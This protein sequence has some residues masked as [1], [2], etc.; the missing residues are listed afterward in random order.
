MRVHYAART[1]IGLVRGENQD[2][3][4]V[5]GLVSAR[6]AT[7]SGEAAVS[8]LDPP[9]VFGVFDGLGGHAGGGIASRIAAMVVGSAMGVRTER[10]LTTSLGRANAVVNEEGT[11]RPELAG[12][13]TTAVVVSV[14]GDGFVVGSVGDSMVLRVSGTALEELTSPDRTPDPGRRGGALLTQALG[15]A[16]TVEVHTRTHRLSPPTRLMLAT[17]GLTDVVPRAEIGR[18]LRGTGA[19]DGIVAELVAAAHQLGAPDNVSVVVLDV[20]A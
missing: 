5:D 9:V 2:A 15:P 19:L 10:A 16:S 17:D 8:K 11:R 18:I 12:L 3:V 13:G 6:D 4:L 14:S 20:V 1:D 7:L